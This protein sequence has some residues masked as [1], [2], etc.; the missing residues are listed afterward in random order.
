MKLHDEQAIAE[1]YREA[2]Q[3]ERLRPHPNVVAIL[4]VCRPGYEGECA[5]SIVCEFINGGSLDSLVLDS[6]ASLP[7]EMV[8]NI[9]RDVAAGMGH[10]HAENILHCDLAAR[11]VLLAVVGN[12]FTAKVSDFGHAHAVGAHHYYNVQATA[13]I[14][15]RWAAVEVLEQRKVSREADVW[16]FG[17]TAWEVFERKLPYFEWMSNKKVRKRVCAG[18]RLPAPQRVACPPS[19]YQLMRD[20]WAQAPHDRPSFVEIEA[21]IS[22]LLAAPLPAPNRPQSCALSSPMAVAGG[23]LDLQGADPYF[24]SVSSGGVSSSVSSPPLGS[25]VDMSLQTTQ[26]SVGSTA[27]GLTSVPTETYDNDNDEAWS[28]PSYG[29][30]PALLPAD[31][32]AAG[33]VD[34]VPGSPAPAAL[35]EVPDDSSATSSPDRDSDDDSDTP[36]FIISFASPVPQATVPLPAKVPPKPLHEN[37]GDLAYEELEHRLSHVEHSGEYEYELERR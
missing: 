33:V 2:D 12:R 8:F 36:S 26:Q 19:F 6:Q 4:G 28:A 13:K 20:C 32:D 27:E 18:H 35:P 14:P 16:A 21:R 25:S 37:S 22:A 29:H 15:V 24:D 5:P 30:S 23:V 11:N 3:M 17:V 1:F 9:L 7:L 31:S 34:V 10:L